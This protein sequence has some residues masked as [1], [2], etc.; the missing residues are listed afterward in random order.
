WGQVD[1]FDTQVGTADVRV[2][3]SQ[4][5]AG[6]NESKSWLDSIPIVKETRVVFR[7]IYEGFRNLMGGDGEQHGGAWNGARSLPAFARGGHNG[8][9]LPKSG[10]GTETTDGFLAFNSRGI[11]AAHL[12]AGEW[13]I[14]GRSSQKYNRELA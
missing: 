12:D 13:I 11:P 4:A 6:I 2:D 8:Y 7:A 10:P 3:N 5:K 1:G 9:R 14:N